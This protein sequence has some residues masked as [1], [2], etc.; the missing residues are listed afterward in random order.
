MRTGDNMQQTKKNTQRRGNADE[1]K[2]SETTEKRLKTNGQWT[3]PLK[4]VYESGNGGG[5]S[6]ASK[7]PREQEASEDAS[8]DTVVASLG[9]TRMVD[10]QA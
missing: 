1:S 9:R 7:A 4:G 5:A 2:G 10:G 6:Q 3:R 8:N